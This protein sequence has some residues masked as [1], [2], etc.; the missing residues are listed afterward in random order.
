MS[1]SLYE[2]LPD[3]INKNK[4]NLPDDFSDIV[5]CVA[6]HENHEWVEV[7]ISSDFF[8]YPCCTL[9]GEH[10]L[11][12]TF[13]DKHLDSLD[14]DWNNLYKHSLEDIKKSYFEHIKTEYW[15]KEE[16]DLY[17]KSI[18][19]LIRLWQFVPESYHTYDLDF[20]NQLWH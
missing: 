13:R 11:N 5:Y 7:E 17:S 20:D 12:K 8:V 4:S 14:K 10:Q 16:T 18:I 6:Y 1:S 15:K 19:C 2:N 3:K 9:H